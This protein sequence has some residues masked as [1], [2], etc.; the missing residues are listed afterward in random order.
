MTRHEFQALISAFGAN[1]QRWPENARQGA[2]QFIENH[3]DEAKIMMQYEKEL[4]QRLDR[5]QIIG[6]T[7]TLKSRILAVS[8]QTIQESQYRNMSWR[9]MAAMMIATFSIG[10]VG[11]RLSVQTP[12][13]VP[14][15]Y[16]VAENADLYQAA[17]D[18]GLDDIYAW[19][20]GSGT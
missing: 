15:E 17:D 16:V 7:E 4:D 12:T 19:V 2:H 9:S 13:E 20:D 5:S 3:P 8:E 10:M 18:L 6:E 1:P 11:G 14:S